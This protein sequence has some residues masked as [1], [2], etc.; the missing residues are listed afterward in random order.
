MLLLLVNAIPY[1][2]EEIN[3]LS[4]I[5]HEFM[6]EGKGRVKGQWL[7]FCFIC[8]EVTLEANWGFISS[9]GQ[10]LYSRPKKASALLWT[11]TEIM[12]SDKPNRLNK[13]W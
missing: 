2:S 8:N 5:E 10:N 13:K 7:A 3:D 1:A 6:V 12:W 4:E 11:A 9:Q